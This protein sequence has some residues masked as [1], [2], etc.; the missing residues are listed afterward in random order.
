MN[1]KLQIVLTIFIII[2]GVFASINIFATN[3]RVDVVENKVDRNNLKWSIDTIQE[4]IWKLDDRY[5][6][7]CERCNP[8]LKAEYRRLVKD[9]GDLKLELNRIL[10][11]G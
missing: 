9:L 10:G 8:E 11:K 7:G 6:E 4:R 1:S 5:G 2:A 3:E